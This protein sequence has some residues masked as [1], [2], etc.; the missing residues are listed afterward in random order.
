[1]LWWKPYYAN[2]AMAARGLR[3]LAVVW[4]A[5][6]GDS[7]A[8]RTWRQRADTLARQVEHSVRAN[9]R[10]DLK[11]PYIGPLP[12][13]TLTF[14]ESLAKEVPSEQQW[15]H[16]AY[17]ELLQADVLP[18][19]LAHLV[20][21]CMRGH[22]AT[23][24]GVVANVAPVT[25]DG[26][27]ML[28]FIS[29]GYAQQLLRLERIDEY[30]LFLYAH[31]HHAHTP[32]SWTAGEVSDI[33]GGMPLFCMPA[34]LTIP[35]LLRWM[36]VFEDSDGGT[37]YLGRAIPR[38]WMRSR[39]PIGI[40]AAPTR[41]GRTGFELCASENGTIEAVVNLPDREMPPSVWLSLRIAE[42]KALASVQLNGATVEQANLRGE[43][44]KLQGM[45]G[46]R[47][48]VVARVA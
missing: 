44:V 27:D 28:G 10:H 30:L 43:A 1:M 32:G 8:A 25:P 26:R 14:R 29:Y 16:R 13:V 5:L 6:A 45:A 23:S 2:S 4:P 46:Q 39:K 38:A 40:H 24:I 17:A 36:L 15:P 47:V 41:W 34:Q 48:H 3:D 42:G 11:P 37:L 22:G 35:L 9:V 31:R 20:I 18:D 33:N 21:N 12:G 7:T 19:D